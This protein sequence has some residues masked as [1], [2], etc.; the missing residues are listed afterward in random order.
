[1]RFRLC[2]AINVEVTQRADF[3]QVYTNVL[4][5]WSFEWFQ[6]LRQFFVSYISMFHRVSVMEFCTTKKMS[7]WWTKARGAGHGRCILICLSILQDVCHMWSILILPRD[8]ALNT[9]GSIALQGKSYLCYTWMWFR[10]IQTI[11][12]VDFQG[13][14]CTDCQVKHSWIDAFICISIDMDFMGVGDPFWTETGGWDASHDMHIEVKRH[15]DQV[16]VQVLMGQ[17]KPTVVADKNWYSSLNG[18]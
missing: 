14:F 18:V 4:A 7:H 15:T 11:R 1:M 3:L 9:V 17:I 8:K 16:Y 2:L 10:R 12:W 6:I 5:E 13:M